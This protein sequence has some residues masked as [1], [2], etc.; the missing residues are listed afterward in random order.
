MIVELRWS[1]AGILPRDHGY[2]LFGALCHRLPARVHR[3]ERAWT[4]STVLPDAAPVVDHRLAREEG[5][6]LRFEHGEIRVRCPLRLMPDFIRLHTAQ[7]LVVGEGHI[8]IAEAPTVHP[9]MPARELSARLVVLRRPSGEDELLPRED[10]ARLLAER[11]REQLGLRV[12]TRP[13]RATL[14]LGPVGSI[15]VAADSLSHGYA[16]ELRELPPDVSL[17]LQ[18]QGV[19]GRVRMGCGFFLASR[20]AP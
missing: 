16:V 7:G 9:L 2:R 6:G 11:L 18:E 12:T 3:E 1:I 4:M 8:S 15:R 17:R 13:P 19:G 14:H 20:G 5:G 10:F